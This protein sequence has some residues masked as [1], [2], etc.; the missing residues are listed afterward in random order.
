MSTNMAMKIDDFEAR[1]RELAL[2]GHRIF[3]GFEK[4]IPEAMMQCAADLL[5][6]QKGGRERFEELVEQM[7]DGFTD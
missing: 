4:F 1:V 7:L 3:V 2:Q 5:A 6:S